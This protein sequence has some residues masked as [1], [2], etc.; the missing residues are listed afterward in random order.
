MRAK[1]VGQAEAIYGL[2][3][4]LMIVMAIITW[5]ET[6]AS[7]G[8]TGAFLA[9]ALVIGLTLL[10]LLLATRRRSRVSL[11]LLV[12]LTI[13]GVGGYLWQVASGVLSVGLLGVLTTVQTLTAVIAVVL[14]LRPAARAWF[15]HDAAPFEDVA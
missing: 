11:W 10:F 2:S 9:N 6:V 12:A 13:I 1:A 14:L 8:M 4:V 5:P 3:V 15:A 7:V